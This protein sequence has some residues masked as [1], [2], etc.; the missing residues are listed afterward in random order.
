MV[1]TVGIVGCRTGYRREK[2]GGQ[3]PVLL[4]NARLGGVRSQRGWFLVVVIYKVVDERSGSGLFQSNNAPVKA[5][6]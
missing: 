1:G 4:G 3:G 2:E 6:G 5:A